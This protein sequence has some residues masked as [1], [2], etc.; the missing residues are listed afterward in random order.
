M[1]AVLLLTSCRAVDVSETSEGTT[2][3]VARNDLSAVEQ[4]TEEAETYISLPE[5]LESSELDD[6]C[7]FYNATGVSLAYIKAGSLSGYYTYGMPII[8]KKDP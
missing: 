2:S 3:E 4:R 7:S 5:R 8:R 1:V 6:I